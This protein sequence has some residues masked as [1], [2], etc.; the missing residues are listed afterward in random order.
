MRAPA[1]R[2]TISNT[3]EPT[4]TA[5]MVMLK[6]LMEEGVAAIPVA[7]RLPEMSPA[8][9]VFR[10][11]SGGGD[12]VVSSGGG[13]VVSGGGSVVVSDGG[14]VV[15]SGGLGVVMMVFGGHMEL[16]PMNITSARCIQLKPGRGKNCR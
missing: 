14:G 6:E 2:H 5:V 7:P 15:V 9:T 13:V 1:R 10:E 4:D 16:L 8:L 12:E 11:V 3:T